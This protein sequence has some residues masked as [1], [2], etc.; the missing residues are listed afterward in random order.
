MFNDDRRSSADLDAYLTRSD[1]ERDAN[2]HRCKCG[3]LIMY[4]YCQAQ[5]ENCVCGCAECTNR[6]TDNE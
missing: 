6:E 3:H 2:P 5:R 1:D 4:G